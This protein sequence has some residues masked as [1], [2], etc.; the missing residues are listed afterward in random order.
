MKDVARSFLM[1]E[2]YPNV[3]GRVPNDYDH[4]DIKRQGMRRRKGEDTTLSN[5]KKTRNFYKDDFIVMYKLSVPPLETP[6]QATLTSGAM[7]SLAGDHPGLV[8]H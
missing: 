7:S 4:S 6:D 5:A 1:I 8:K 3:Q 2:V